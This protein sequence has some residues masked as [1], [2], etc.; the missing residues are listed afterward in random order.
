[1]PGTDPVPELARVLAVTANRV[2]LMWSA[3][4]VRGR[5]EDGA[6][7]LRRVADDLL[8]ASPSTHQRRLLVTVDQ[9][10]ELFT[11][12]PPIARQRFAQLVRDAVAGPVQVL[13]I[14]RSEFL[15]DGRFLYPELAGVQV[16]AYLLDPL[17][18]EMLRDVIEQPVRLARLHLE[19]GLA[20]QLVADTDSGEALPLLAF[21]LHE[22]ADG[23]SP[24]G[25][26]T[27]ARYQNLGGV[28]GGLAR[29]ADA[30]LADA[31][32]ASGL[33]ERDVLIGLTRLV[34]VDETGRRAR[35]KI[36]LGSLLQPL[37]VAL[38]VFVERRLLLSD[39]DDDQQVSLTMTH[40]ALLTEWRPLDA[41]TADV[42]A[43][44]RAARA[45]EQAA[46][47]W[48]NAGRSKHYLWDNER[49]TTSSYSA[50]VSVSAGGSQA[51]V[52][53]S[54][55]RASSLSSPHLVAVSR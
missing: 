16:E 46:A 47:D 40:E 43:A 48:D 9:A 31:V 2:G 14:L 22:L 18:R 17:G 11:R 35:R 42:T 50:G 53:K 51:P 29:H 36:R 13:A 25:M 4:D 7:G 49:L 28:H 38:Q 15:A 21:T 30:A 10:E 23:L 27:L 24:G 55:R 34:A 26:L 6:D 8:A 37:R 44:L 33:T 52:V 5:L 39:T 3:S 32:Q 41:A 54:W 20:A 45:V 12:A 19:A 1:M